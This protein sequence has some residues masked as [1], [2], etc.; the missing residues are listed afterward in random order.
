MAL[1]VPW[2]SNVG[3]LPSRA[4][5]HLN[6]QD[7][8]PIYAPFRDGPSRLYALSVEG[9]SAADRRH[10][11]HAIVEGALLGDISIVFLMMQVYLPVP[12]VQTLLRTAAA[13]PIVMLMQRR[14]FKV[15]LMATV[16]AYILF[17]ALVGPLLA[18]TAIDVAV[19]GILIGLGRRWGLP[20]AINI[21]WTGPVFAVLDLIIPTIVTIYLF[22][23]P[24][25]KLIASARHF[26]A[27]L[28]NLL[29]G[30]FNLSHAPA[31]VI[32]DLHLAE[33]A[34]VADWVL[35]WVGIMV[36]YGL[37]TMYLVAIVSE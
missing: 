34:W 18:L 10:R 36:L 24:V 23:Y 29:I 15:A 28:F 5:I 9:E 4:L 2:V 22:Q 13:V 33:H 37:L 32:H 7:R 16:A 25:K 14:G 35:V 30:V 19:A 11:I 1:P 17:S 26:V 21:L 6:P 20:A 3:I 31:G 27:F 12:V 8:S